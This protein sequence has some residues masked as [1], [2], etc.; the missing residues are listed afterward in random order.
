MELREAG[1]PV[2]KLDSAF[3]ARLSRYNTTAKVI[4]AQSDLIAGGYLLSV[5]FLHLGVDA[6]GASLVMGVW[7]EL[8][9]GVRKRR[10]RVFLSA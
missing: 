8:P 7:G 1:I 10:V 3:L 2:G 9:Q 5:Y 6:F 4:S